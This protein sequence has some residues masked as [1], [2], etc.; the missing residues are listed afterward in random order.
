MDFTYNKKSFTNKSLPAGR[1]PSGT[2]VTIKCKKVTNQLVGPKE[3]LCTQEGI[4]E[5][6]KDNITCGNLSYIPLWLAMR[7][8]AQLY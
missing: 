7:Y 2:K 6:Y 5:G 4:W 1:Y 8:N 3:M